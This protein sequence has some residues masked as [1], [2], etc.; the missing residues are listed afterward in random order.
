MLSVNPDPQ[1]ALAKLPNFTKYSHEF[2]DKTL[3]ENTVTTYRF[4][5]V[6]DTMDGQICATQ[7]NI[8]K[9]FFSRTI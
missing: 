2:L 8:L 3:T 4:E 5:L 6:A 9:A 1:K 7:D